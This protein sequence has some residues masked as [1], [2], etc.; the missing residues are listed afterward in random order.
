MTQCVDKLAENPLQIDIELWYSYQHEIGNLFRGMG[1]AIS[2]AFSDIN[3]KAL[4]IKNN[5][6]LFA[7]K[8]GEEIA[9]LQEFI[10][11]EKEKGI[12]LLNGKSNASMLPKELKNSWQSTYASTS[13]TMLRNIW[14]NDFLDSLY[15]NV[16]D[17]KD[18]SLYDCTKEAYNGTLANYHIWAVR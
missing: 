18:K 10:M 17:N 12:Q 16:V 6:G 8:Y 7:E 3:K 2:A 14:F 9:T 15:S 5:K 13:R 11:K 1:T 4:T